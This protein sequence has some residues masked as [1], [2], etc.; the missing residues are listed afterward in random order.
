M[1]ANELGI[2]WVSVWVS[3]WAPQIYDSCENNLDLMCVFMASGGIVFSC[4]FLLCIGLQWFWPAK[5]VKGRPLPY[6][7]KR[8]GVVFS[9]RLGVFFGGHH[10]HEDV[11]IHQPL[12]RKCLFEFIAILKTDS[13]HLLHT[14]HVLSRALKLRPLGKHVKICPAAKSTPFKTNRGNK[15]NT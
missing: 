15:Y 14:S 11:Y 9:A 2:G 7:I 5:Q 12:L 1:A 6:I 4:F 8:R 13:F 3:V 10:S